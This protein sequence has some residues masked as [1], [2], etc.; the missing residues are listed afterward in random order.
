[1][2]PEHPQVVIADLAIFRIGAVIA[3]NNP[4]YTERELEYQLN[5]SGAKVIITMS[6]LVPRM[7]GLMKK[8]K[9]RKSLPA[10]FIHTCRFP[11]AA[12]PLREKGDAPGDPGYRE[13]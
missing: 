1:V 10:I 7:Q 8:T 13:P 9:I 11:K 3:Q 12:L 2:P 5:D 6:L 4:L